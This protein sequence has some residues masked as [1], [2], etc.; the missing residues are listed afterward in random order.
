MPPHP[1]GVF[2]SKMPRHNIRHFSAIIFAFV[3]ALCLTACHSKRTTVSSGGGRKPQSSAP[4]PR[5]LERIVNGENNS[6][7][8]EA[9]KWLGTPYRYGGMERGK[10]TDCSGMVMSIYSTVTGIKIPRSSAAQQQWCAP[11]K[12]SHLQAGDLVFFATGSKSHKVS[13]VGLYVG[14]DVFIHASGSRGVIASSLTED[15]YKRHFHSAGRVHGYKPSKKKKRT[16]D[17]ERAAPFPEQDAF[18]VIPEPVSV[19]EPVTV[20]PEPVPEPATVLEPVAPEPAPDAPFVEPENNTEPVQPQATEPAPL[21]EP[22]TP[23]EPGPVSEPAPAPAPGYMPQA[24]PNPQ[25]EPATPDEPETIST[26][27]RNAMKF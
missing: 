11:L 2:V 8:V 9:R 25:P 15:Y 14:D 7:V 17:E 20:C 16:K 13:H 23:T 4:V 3:L 19:P 27:V 24:S 21:V 18:P 1:P 22:E 6:L 5:E 26:R 10:G 12:R